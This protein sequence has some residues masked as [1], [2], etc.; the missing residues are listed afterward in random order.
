[1][2]RTADTMVA[3]L[4]GEKSF[5]IGGCFETCLF[6]EREKQQLIFFFK[7]IFFFICREEGNMR[8]DAVERYGVMTK[9]AMVMVMV[10]TESLTGARSDD[11]V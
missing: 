8:C 6:E 3:I 4:M 2:S 10:M 9:E 7:K 11:D 5:L 1:M